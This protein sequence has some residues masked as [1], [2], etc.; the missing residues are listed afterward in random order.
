MQN[1]T[2]SV[3]GKI[4]SASMAAGLASCLIFQEQKQKNI[5]A[6]PDL[7]TITLNG[8]QGIRSATVIT[9]TETENRALPQNLVHSIQLQVNAQEKKEL[10]SLSFASL[11]HF[12]DEADLSRSDPI[13][14]AT[15]KAAPPP[16]VTS[17][18]Q[19]YIQ[20]GDASNPQEEIV[21]LSTI[22]NAAWEEIKRKLHIFQLIYAT[23]DVVLIKNGTN[24]AFDGRNQHA[25]E[26]AFRQVEHSKYDT[27]S[28]ATSKSGI[29]TVP[30]EYQ[31][32]ITSKAEEKITMDLSKM[33]PEEWSSQRYIL[34]A[35]LAR[36]I[37]MDYSDAGERKDINSSFGLPQ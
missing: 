21:H 16:A 32:E 23:S 8:D 27:V 7:Q 17:S 1:R 2:V 34:E 4:T 20:K 11:E 37:Y 26:M 14:F 19:M 29:P 5:S 33:S 35:W 15:S 18:Y 6:D 28:F 24:I 10:S 36:A 9:I 13:F 31:L 30:I 3:L 12:L 25:F 22:D